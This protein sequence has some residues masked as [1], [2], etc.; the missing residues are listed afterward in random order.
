MTPLRKRM[1]NAMVLRGFAKRTQMSYLTA[2]A[3]M[4]RHLNCDPSSL[5][6]DQV[7]GYLLHLLQDRQRSRSTV[8]VTACAIR[9]LFCDVLGQAE[10]RV[11][12]PLGK[13]SQRLPDL[14]SREEM[15]ALLEAPMSIKAKTFLM[16]AYA[17]G[18]RLNELCH[19]RGSDIDAAPDRMC[20]RVEEGKGGKGR[21]SILTPDLLAQLRLYWRACKVGASGSD[22][23]FANRS[24]PSRPL[25]CSSAQ[26][27]YYSARTAAGITKS[28]G[29]HCL[30]HCFATH[31]LE[32]GI[33][34]CSISKLLGHAHLNTTGRYLRM[35]RPGLSAGDDALALLSQLPLKPKGMG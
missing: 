24:D 16:T 9:F 23:L 17:T 19:L 28:G 29:I 22:W 11:K 1:T 7:Q 2:V 14:L 6:D 33:D 31:L 26:R 8:N 20:I 25:D 4:A 34:L 27:Y 13:A 12:I 21:Y 5:S 3:Q 18:L 32:A 35:A 30:R 10:R 15:A